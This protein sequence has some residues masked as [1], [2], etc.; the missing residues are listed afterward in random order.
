VAVVTLVNVLS[1]KKKKKK[2]KK[3]KMGITD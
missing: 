1:S 2:K 3:R